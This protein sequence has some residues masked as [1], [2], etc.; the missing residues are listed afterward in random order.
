MSRKE[1]PSRVVRV[2]C[3][4]DE[5]LIRLLG[6]PRS[7]IR[8]ENN[9]GVLCNRLRRQENH[10]AVIDEDPASAQPSYLRDVRV[11][12][13]SHGVRVLEDAQ[14]GHRIIVLCPRLEGWILKVARR[15]GIRPEDYGLPPDEDG[16]HKKIN[17]RL[18]RFE[19]LFRGLLERKCPELD[20]L[21]RWIRAEREGATGPRA[22]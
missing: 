5:R 19:D 15:N 17:L 22:L 21:R 12:E 2:E 4:P 20:D 1:P 7:R 18:Q 8:H 10:I 11:V 6:V 9:K 3:K 14:R 16:L 13:D